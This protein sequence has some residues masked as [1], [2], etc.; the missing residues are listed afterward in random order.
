M[1]ARRPTRR[2]TIA[3]AAVTIVASLALGGCTVAASTPLSS[4]PPAAPTIPAPST[5]AAPH[6]A[7]S[8]TPRETPPTATSTTWGRIWDALPASFPIPSGSEPTQAATAGGTGAASATLAVPL[9][10]GDASGW[11]VG[12]LAADH[13][14]VSGASGPYESGGYVVDATGA[15]SGCRTEIRLSPANT[16]S[17]GATSTATILLAAACP[18]H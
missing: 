15:G 4:V 9:A 8:P 17:S 1:D 14:N 6:S 5:V 10:P 3:C 16:T 2:T 13:F 18:F 12:A 7:P 11:Y